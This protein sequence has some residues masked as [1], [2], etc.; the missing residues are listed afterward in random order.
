MDIPAQE[1]GEEQ[2][3]IRVTPFLLFDG[4]RADKYGAHW[5][6]RGGRA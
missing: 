4:N 3:V 1:S 2:P 5:F 6:F